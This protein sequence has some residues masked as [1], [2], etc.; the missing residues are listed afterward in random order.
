VLLYSNTV[1]L[2]QECVIYFFLNFAKAVWPNCKKTLRSHLQY[3]LVHIIK[4]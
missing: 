3:I 1:T 2:I 4:I